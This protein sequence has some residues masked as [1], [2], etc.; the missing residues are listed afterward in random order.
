MK[1]ALSTVLLTILLGHPLAH[2][3][4][5]ES[6]L[7]VLVNGVEGHE[8]SWEERLEE[9]QVAP[10]KTSKVPEAFALLPFI[11]K[12]QP[13]RDPRLTLEGGERTLREAVQEL[14]E[15]TELRIV[16]MTEARQKISLL[17][18]ERNAFDT[19][20]WL[21]ARNVPFT[22]VMEAMVAQLDCWV[23]YRDDLVT[24]LPDNGTLKIKRVALAQWMEDGRL[25]EDDLQEWEDYLEEYDL[26]AK[27]ITETYQ[28]AFATEAP[29]G[30]QFRIY[31][32]SKYGIGPGENEL[33][34]DAFQSK[35]KELEGILYGSVPEAA[36]AGFQ[37]EL[38]EDLLYVRG[39]EIVVQAIEELL[40]AVSPLQTS[41]PRRTRDRP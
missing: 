7:I 20:I 34:T 2:A 1:L 17:T 5:A 16:F 29:Q 38:T 10:P 41:T 32:L 14:E 36:T 22:K 23:H 18:S 3:V 31:K 12:L 6:E 9:T 39:P 37:I 21:Q 26:Y 24:I 27:S 4:T 30:P 19:T 25:S 40:D 28:K 8:T 11:P 33:S 13:V 15:A 35:L